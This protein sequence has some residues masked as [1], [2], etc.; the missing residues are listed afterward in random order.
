MGK[1]EKRTRT[2]WE[3]LRLEAR[4]S[5]EASYYNDMNAM[6]GQRLYQSINHQRS[7]F[8]VLTDRFDLSWRGP[9]AEQ[10][11]QHWLRVLKEPELWTRN[12]TLWL[13]YFWHCNGLKTKRDSHCWMKKPQA[14]THGV[15]CCC[16]V[17]GMLSNTANCLQL[18]NNSLMVM[19]AWPVSPG[20][21][22]NAI[23]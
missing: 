14:L 19:P 7:K 16:G 22:F 1:K 6:Q 5:T 2:R 4:P 15:I 13:N 3:S 18:G 9:T 23:G 20:E 11:R 21:L 10:T 12:T 17:R 8:T